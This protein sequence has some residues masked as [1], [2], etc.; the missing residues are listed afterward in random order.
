MTMSAEGAALQTFACA[1]PSG[2]IDS[3]LP[4]RAD[5]RGYSLP[6]LR[7]ST[8]DFFSGPT[9]RILLVSAIPGLERPG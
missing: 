3:L 5:A 6:A 9:R 2:L 7:A 4:P 1:G 8:A